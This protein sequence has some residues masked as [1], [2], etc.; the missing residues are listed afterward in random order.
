MNV[1]NLV[2]LHYAPDSELPE[3]C[4]AINPANERQIVV[5]LRGHRGYYPYIQMGRSPDG[6][7]AQAVTAW[8]DELGV[9]PEQTKVMVLRSMFTWKH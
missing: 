6:F 3:L 2:D 7:A 8:N 4:Y 1:S 5:I 9:S